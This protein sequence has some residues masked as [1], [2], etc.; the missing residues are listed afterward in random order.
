MQVKVR[1]YD[2][3]E[4]RCASVEGEETGVPGLV[5]TPRLRPRDAQPVEGEYVVTHVPTGLE[6]PTS[7]PDVGMFFP[8]SDRETLFLIA[9]AAA[10]RG[11]DWSEVTEESVTDGLK[12]SW[13]ECIEEAWF[14][15]V[16]S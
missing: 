6:V 9:A 16:V 14:A 1:Y 12:Q 5:I 10:R 13:H 2:G 3:D 15:P 4:F 8:V 11:M 7:R